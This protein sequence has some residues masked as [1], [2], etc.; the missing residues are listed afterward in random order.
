MK[1][2]VSSIYEIDSHYEMQAPPT[3]DISV[4]VIESQARQIVN[5]IIVDF[6]EKEVLEWI[7]NDK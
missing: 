5:D 7:E 4:C 3:F 2:N 6:G 1:I